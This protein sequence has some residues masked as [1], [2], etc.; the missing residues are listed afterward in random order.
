MVAASAPTRSSASCAASKHH[1]AASARAGSC[2]ASRA[3]VRPAVAHAGRRRR[4]PLGG[5]RIVEQRDGD[6]HRDRPPRLGERV[7]HPQLEPAAGPHRREERGDVVGEVVGRR[8]TER[9][10]RRRSTA[11]TS[12]VRAGRR[13]GCR[14]RAS[15]SPVRRARS[16]LQSGA[17]LLRR[18]WR[19]RRRGPCRDRWRA[20]P[21]RASRGSPTVG[22]VASNGEFAKHAV[23]T[24][25]RSCARCQRAS[26]SCGGTDVDVDLDRRGVAH[27]RAAGRPRGVEVLL[28][29]SRSAAR[30]A[31]ARRRHRVSMP[32]PTR[33]I[34]ARGERCAHVRVGAHGRDGGAEPRR[35]GTAQLQLPAGLERDP[36]AARE[37]GQ[38]RPA[39]SA[40]AQ[41]AA[42]VGDGDPLELDADLSL[43]PTVGPQSSGRPARRRSG[44]RRR[45]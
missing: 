1:R 36:A 24:G 27:H 30:A 16:R 40:G 25:P 11:R 23:S 32:V 12:E 18:S 34:P 7:D 3:A 22:R 43:R 35:R 17:R 38:Q 4:R 2:N 13:S 29:R 14:R 39:S 44:G 31:R 19:P 37:V 6:G 20:T 41:D 26:T 10:G 45:R 9:R 15:S 33:S 42:V 28:H 8:P 5:E 21:R